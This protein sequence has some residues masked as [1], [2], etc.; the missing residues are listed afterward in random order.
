MSDTSSTMTNEG[1]S[2]IDTSPQFPVK[3][4]DTPTPSTPSADEL[5]TIKQGVMHKRP[6]TP[7]PSS[8]SADELEMVRQQGVIPKRLS[9]RPLP[10]IPKP[11]PADE[12]AAGSPSSGELPDPEDFR[13]KIIEILCDTSD[14][15][16]EIKKLFKIDIE[17]KGR[18]GSRD[19]NSPR[20]DRTASKNGKVTYYVLI[21][22][23]EEIQFFSD[24]EFKGLLMSGAYRCYWNRIFLT[25]PFGV[26]KTSLAKL[27]VGDEAPEERESTDG[28]WIYLGRAGMDIKERCWIFLKH[29]TIL[30]AT[31]QSLLRSKEVTAT[32]KSVKSVDD[33]EEPGTVK[34]SEEKKNQDDVISIPD[35]GAVT[36]SRNISKPGALKSQDNI[37]HAVKKKSK[38]QAFLDLPSRLRKAFTGR[39]PSNI[40]PQNDRAG[41]MDKTKIEKNL[42]GKDMS[43]EEIIKLGDVEEQRTSLENSIEELFQNHGGK[44]HLQY[45]PLIFVNARNKDDEELAT[46]KKQLVDVALD[47]PRAVGN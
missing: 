9:A 36:H 25:G 13:R 46:L 19:G 21:G 24:K 33:K 30:N 41:K 1:D 5:E 31:V 12:S 22:L 18:S 16:E 32:V 35:A 45:K 15:P 3:E 26:G 17:A 34:Q 2:I 28:I 43:E 11:T 42:T 4:T 27:L 14:N 7:T 40:V 47:H 23:K 29:G 39:T 37:P 38:L 8:L 6:D 44:K 10:P 20:R